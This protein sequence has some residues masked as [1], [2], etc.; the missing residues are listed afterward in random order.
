MPYKDPQRQREY[1]A[2]WYAKNGDRHRANVRAYKAK[3]AELV[4][5]KNREYGMR[6]RAR[7]SR[8]K[9]EWNERNRERQ[10]ESNRRWLNANRELARIICSRSQF[11]RAERKAETD[12]AWRDRNP[13]KIYEYRIRADR[14]KRDRITARE[15]ERITKESGNE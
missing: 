13:K 6:N 12:R 1:S 3:H 4:R 9:R 7:L 10:R 2:S 5:E 15:W 14:R 8:Q 11:W